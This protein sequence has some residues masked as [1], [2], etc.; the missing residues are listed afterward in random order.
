MEHEQ[1]PPLAHQIP[2]ACR[3]LGIGRS[4]MYELIKAGDIK[5]IKVGTRTLIPEAQLVQFIATRMAV[6][7]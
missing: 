5:P 4:A 1:L 6:A 2:A 7:A 3:R